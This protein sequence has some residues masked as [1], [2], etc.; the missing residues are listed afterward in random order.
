MIVTVSICS[1]Q[2][3]VSP[4]AE[5]STSLGGRG[6]FCH[7]PENCAQGLH[8]G[9]VQYRHSRSIRSA[10]VLA[11]NTARISD[12]GG[13]CPWIS[14][15]SYPPSACI[16]EIFS[17]NSPLICAT[18]WAGETAPVVS[19]GPAKKMPSGE[20]RM[21]PHRQM[22]T[23]TAITTPTACCSRG[24]QSLSC[25]DHS[26]ERAVCRLCGLS[27]GHTGHLCGLLGSCQPGS[28]LRRTAG[29]SGRKRSY[30]RFPTRLSNPSRF[31]NGM[32][33]RFDRHASFFYCRLCGAAHSLPGGLHREAGAA[34][35]NHLSAQTLDVAACGPPY[36]VAVF[37]REELPRGRPLSQA[38]AVPV[39]P[40]RRRLP[41]RS[42]IKDAFPAAR[43]LAVWQAQDRLASSDRRPWSWYFSFEAFGVRTGGWGRL[44]PALCARSGSPASFLR[45]RSFRG[46]ILSSLGFAASGV[47]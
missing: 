28:R 18:A 19:S 21:M 15:V 41:W 24:G 17:P 34:H 30:R 4:E 29:L 44:L 1:V 2:A 27:G 37:P 47:S 38:S 11:A 13:G 5:C 42:R 10:A 25:R 3:G 33:S 45:R 39:S 20:A 26:A 14:S 22:T 8:I 12:Q 23:T 9:R 16:L 31:T 35:E 32:A 43:R 40:L 46:R 6:K 36:L 7:V